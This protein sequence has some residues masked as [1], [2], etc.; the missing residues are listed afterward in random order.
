MKHLRMSKWT[1]FLYHWRFTK[2]GLLRKINPIYILNF[3]TWHEV[4]T[5]TEDTPPQIKTID[6]MY[7][8]ISLVNVKL[9]KLSSL[10]NNYYFSVA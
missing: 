6:D 10:A 8:A 5:Y 7:R 4:Q 9:L 2:Q 3:L 1:L